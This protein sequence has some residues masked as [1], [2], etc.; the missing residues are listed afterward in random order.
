MS[1]IKIKEINYGEYG[2]CMQI[3]NGDVEVVVTVDMGP[4]IISYSIPGKANMFCN[5]FDEVYDKTGWKILGG[6]RVW[7]SPEHD[8][9]SYDPDNDPIEFEEIEGG[10]HVIGNP[11]KT[12]G[13]QKEMFIKI[14]EEGTN[15]LVHHRIT[16]ISLRPIDFS[17]W[18]LSVMA[19]GG[20]EVVPICKDDTG[21]LG[22]CWLGLWPY[23][24]MNDPR[25]NWGDKYIT[26]QQDTNA[27]SNFKFGITNPYGWAAYFLEG[28]AFVKNFQFD[29]N[30]KY[31]DNGMNYETFT[32]DFMLEMESLSTLEK[33]EPND[34]LEH[35]EL[36]SI[37]D[38][39]ECPESDDDS[40]HETLTN[41][42]SCGCEEEEDGCGCGCSCG[43][44]ETHHEGCG[45]DG[46][47]GD[48]CSCDEGGCC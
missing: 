34:F 11:E 48:E 15:V 40:I 35:V 1:N 22:N 6:H 26:L 4:R 2:R 20:K 38:D 39:V 29:P 47:C 46:D 30:G 42:F 10:L 16:N 36:W 24:K 37:V 19:P 31:P 3:S 32:N 45:C 33:V 23:T 27:T 9:L 12:S 43:G 28:M 17:V 13:L 21:L 18:C 7:V 41:M 44:E 5:K 14:D 25:V 8:V